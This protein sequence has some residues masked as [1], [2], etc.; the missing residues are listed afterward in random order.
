MKRGVWRRAKTESCNFSD[1]RVTCCHVQN[2]TPQLR[3]Q[4]ERAAELN[5]SMT[6]HHATRASCHPF[7][8]SSQIFC[9]GMWDTSMRIKNTLID[10]LGTCSWLIIF[11]I[12]SYTPGSERSWAS[13]RKFLL[14]TSILAF[15][16]LGTL[17][18][19]SKKFIHLMVAHEST[20]EYFWS[21]Q[22]CIAFKKRNVILTSHLQLRGSDSTHDK[23]TT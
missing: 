23:F 17:F 12:G 18:S 15:L 10:V 22:I 11:L 13:L 8:C 1:H 7:H 21:T 9:C 2:W 14:R 5:K 20:H 6:N 19:F 16:H 4:G 3:L